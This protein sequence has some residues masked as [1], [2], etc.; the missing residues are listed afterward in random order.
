MQKA[1]SL[2]RNPPWFSN[3]SE[4]ALFSGWGLVYGIESKVDRVWNI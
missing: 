2:L 3:K 4:N 1:Y